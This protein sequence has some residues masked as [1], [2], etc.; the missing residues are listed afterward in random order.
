MVISIGF[1]F[2]KDVADAI[3]TKPRDMGIVKRLAVLARCVI[4]QCLIANINTRRKSMFILRNYRVLT[5]GTAA[6]TR[7]GTAPA[8]DL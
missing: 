7:V 8:R 1:L 6:V 2:N 5:G 4:Q 3:I